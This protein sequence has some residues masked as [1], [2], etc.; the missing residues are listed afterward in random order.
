MKFCRMTKTTSDGNRIGIFVRDNPRE[1]N[2]YAV[3][4]HYEDSK[5]HIT[6][7][8]HDHIHIQ[9]DCIMVSTSCGFRPLDTLDDFTKTSAP[10]Q[11]I[12]NVVCDSIES[13]KWKEYWYEF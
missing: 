4:F 2:Y 3:S 7:G 8:F 6:K 10:L 9:P 13:L 1:A 12:Y 11:M 5:S